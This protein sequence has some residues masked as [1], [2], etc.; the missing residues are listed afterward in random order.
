MRTMGRELTFGGLAPLAGMGRGIWYT[1]PSFS[2]PVDTH[3]PVNSS[4]RQK[5]DG[6]PTI[7]ALFLKVL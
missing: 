5:E 7:T 6:K 1:S 2:G 4:N 3:T